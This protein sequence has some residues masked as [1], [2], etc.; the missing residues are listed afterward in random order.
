MSL[1]EYHGRYG[2]D[3]LEVEKTIIQEAV[4][5]R[6]AIKAAGFENTK[7]FVQVLSLDPTMFQGQEAQEE[8][9]QVK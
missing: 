3:S 6:D 1:E 4:R 7:E 5:R 9:E 8:K 2:Q